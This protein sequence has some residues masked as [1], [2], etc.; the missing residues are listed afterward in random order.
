MM[1][2]FNKETAAH[3]LDEA[4]AQGLHKGATETLRDESTLRTRRMRGLGEDSWTS[5]VKNA[6]HRGWVAGQ[7]QRRLEL[8][9]VCTELKGETT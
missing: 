9:K 2:R 6:R 1:R 7:R 8:E 3:L 5:Q 4:Y